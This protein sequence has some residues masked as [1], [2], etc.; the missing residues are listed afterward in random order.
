MG[1]VDFDT[2][3]G[4]Y[5]G[6]GIEEFVSDKYLGRIEVKSVFWKSDTFF[7]DGASLNIALLF[8]YKF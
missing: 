4:G 7:T 6:M 1:A 8:G 2:A 5:I 3:L